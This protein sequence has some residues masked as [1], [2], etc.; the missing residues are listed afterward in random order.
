MYSRGKPGVVH[1]VVHPSDEAA[2]QAVLPYWDEE[3]GAAGA[4]RLGFRSG[5]PS[6]HP[7][8]KSPEG[9]EASSKSLQAFYLLAGFD[10]LTSLRSAGHA[11]YRNHLRREQMPEAGSAQP[12]HWRAERRRCRPFHL[13]RLAP[14]SSAA[15]YPD[16][17]LPTT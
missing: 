13:T 5:M 16:A 11:L 10:R 6:S 9:C 8:S 17:L 1:D 7:P 15:V 14:S 4:V 2:S 3:A 12:E